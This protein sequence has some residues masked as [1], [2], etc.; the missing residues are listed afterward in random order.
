MALTL[1]NS[2][3]ITGID[4]KSIFET[5]LA[6]TMQPYV[7]MNPNLAAFDLNGNGIPDGVD[8]PAPSAS[9]KVGEEFAIRSI[10]DAGDYNGDG[11]F[12]LVYER[13]FTYLPPI[14][15]L[16][17]R[18]GTMS[19]ATITGDAARETIA[20]A[21]H[22]DF[23]GD[24]LVDI[25]GTVNGYAYRWPTTPLDQRGS[26]AGGGDLLLLNQGNNTFTA[27]A[28]SSM[29]D[30]QSGYDLHYNHG[31]HFGDFDNDGDFDLLSIEDNGLVGPDQGVVT[32]KR[33]NLNDG[34]ATFSY[35]DQL[36]PAA[37]AQPDQKRDY[38]YGGNPSARF[39]DLTN[40]GI[41]DLVVS[42]RVQ[43]EGEV[44][45]NGGIHIF[46]N[47]G[48]GDISND[49]VI[50]TKS[51]W[52]L[53]NKAY[54]QSRYTGLDFETAVFGN[55]F[56]NFFDVNDDGYLDILVG[57]GAS[58]EGFG[59]SAGG[60]QLFINEG[61]LSF[62]EA[63]A[64]Y[65]PNLEINYRLGSPAFDDTP[66]PDITRFNYFDINGDGFKDFVME[67]GETPISPI[68]DDG[69][70]PYVMMNYDG[71]YYPVEYRSVVGTFATENGN[72]MGNLIAGDFNGDGLMDLASNAGID[73]SGAVEQGKDNAIVDGIFV[74]LTR[75]QD[76]RVSINDPI[77]G[78]G[79][80]DHLIGAE[81]G[82]TFIPGRGSDRIDGEGG[83]DRVQYWGAFEQFELSESPTGW[84]IIHTDG[85]DNLQQVERLQFTDRN[86]ALDLDG[87]AGATAKLLVT[88]FG[89]EA[90]KNQ[91]YVGVGLHFFD[92]GFSMDQLAGLALGAIG[93]ETPEEII[94][95]LYVNLFQEEPMLEDIQSYIDA[96]QLGDIT[97]NSLVAAAAELTDDLGVID[98]VGLAKAGIEYV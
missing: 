45:R 50:K 42:T 9:L 69:I 31:G 81:T 77:R 84:Q 71:K 26:F 40:D 28:V 78:T 57:Q 74:H 4:F 65:F 66:V 10:D 90:L 18:D 39:G 12:D 8:T 82:D 91:A 23:N 38:Q 83:I 32:Q 34:D 35:A 72:G 56:T 88:I 17:S 43:G 58:F 29:L 30:Y 37:T 22:A 2:Q 55:N 11:I 80:D 86:I 54:L 19:A 67:Q 14:V 92:L 36:I 53:E 24:G 94:R 73:A 60:F 1:S 21:F 68:I 76:A 7:S 20:E 87:A 47:D 48:D 70:F 85:V 3:Y 97:L 64:E 61:G 75:P 51:H 27:S 13:Q 63:T 93:L 95:V 46:V 25:Y 33:I 62:R 15:L 96:V 44:L 79:L 5:K 59:G 98:L 49:L 89:S 52:A 16:G 6:F 41:V